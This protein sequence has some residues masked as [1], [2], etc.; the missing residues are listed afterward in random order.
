MARASMRLSSGGYSAVA[1]PRLTPLSW[2]P[3][4]TSS[5]LSW[6]H[7]AEHRKLS[8]GSRVGEYMSVMYFCSNLQT[9]ELSCWNQQSGTCTTRAPVSRARRTMSGICQR[10]PCSGNLPEAKRR[11]GPSLSLR[12][13]GFS[14]INTPPAVVMARAA[15]HVR[16]TRMFDTLTLA[17]SHALRLGRPRMCCAVRSGR[18]LW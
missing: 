10:E 16:R 9:S 6:A 11:H 3:T 8:A 7:R 18:T 2:K 4:A 15:S 1:W 17:L 14:M 5:W 13:T 12:R